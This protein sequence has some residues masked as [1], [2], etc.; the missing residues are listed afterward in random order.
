MRQ[1]AM[2]VLVATFGMGI[3]VGCEDKTE[4]PAVPSDATKK[5]EDAA[6]KVEEGAKDAYKAA[7]K[8][9]EEGAEKLDEA[10]E[11]LAE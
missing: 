5:V 10:A 3:A 11:K 7:E 9:A 2:L 1:F 4:T 6:K 8:K